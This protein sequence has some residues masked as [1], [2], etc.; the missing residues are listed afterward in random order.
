MSIKVMTAVWDYGPPDSTQRFVLLAIADNAR[1][2]G[3]HTWPSIKE[4]AAKCALSERTVVRAVDALVASG[5]LLRQRRQNTSNLYQIVLDRLRPNSV[6]DNLTLPQATPTTASDKMTPPNGVPVSDRLSLTEVTDCHL[7]GCQDVTHGGDTVSHDPSLIHPSNHQDDPSSAAAP[8]AAPVAA[9][10]DPLTAI[11][12]WLGFDDQLTPKERAGL[13]V[14]TLL[15]WAYWAQIKRAERGSRIANPVGWVRSQWRNGRPL[16]ADLLNLA[17]GWMLL[18]DDGRAR[19]LGRLEWLAD[20]GPDPGTPFEEDFPDIPPRAAA[21]VFAAT[22]GA[23]GPPALSPAEAIAPVCATDR[24]P[25]VE[26]RSAAADRSVPQTG[27]PD[28]N[29]NGRGEAIWPV[30]LDDLQHAMVRATFDQLLRGTTA[31]EDDRGI[32]VR[33]RNEAAV[34]WLQHRLHPVVQRAVDAAA[35]R[36][37]AVRYVVAE[38]AEVYP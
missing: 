15:G 31:V 23:L 16:R 34:E 32:T 20:Y 30:A 21:A 7:G 27:P 12:D 5:Y 29:G 26:E 28:L 38:V 2:D 25:P 33:V 1:D 13:D 9:A 14:S 11:L 17:R 18:S 8:A 35:G 24:T 10:A 36:P 37:L 4:L 3:S 22:G 6:S 19:L